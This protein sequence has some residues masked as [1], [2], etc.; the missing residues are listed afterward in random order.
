MTFRAALVPVLDH[1][2]RTGGIVGYHAVVAEERDVPSSEMHV[3]VATLRRQLEYLGDRYEVLPLWDLIG[4]QACGRRTNRCVAVTFDDAYAGVATLAAPILAELDMPATI[5]V[6]VGASEH[7][8]PYWWDAL[9]LACR[10]DDDAPWERLLASLGIEP[11]P[12]GRAS[13]DVVRSHILGQPSGRLPAGAEFPVMADDTR[14]LLRPLRFT[15]LR[16]LARDARFDFGCHTMTHPVL[17]RLGTAEQADEMRMAHDRIREELPRA[18][19]VVAYPFG[20]H[21]QST[22]CAAR[23]AGMTAAVTMA[24]RALRTSDSALLL[25]RVGISEDW[26][27]EAISL[28]LNRGLE[29]FFRAS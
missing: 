20:L 21:D 10:Q 29:P 17:P 18:I 28:R 12:R 2:F 6:T 22:L 15:E 24:P 19:P 23:R 26:A 8:A 25:P 3:S 7:A 5:F 4:R 13:R 14:A 16:A 9:E 1:L 11:L 27:P